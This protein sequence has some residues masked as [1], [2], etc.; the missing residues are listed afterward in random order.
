MLITL[1]TKALR[2]KAIRVQPPV[3]PIFFQL[4]SNHCFIIPGNFTSVNFVQDKY[5]GRNSGPGISLQESAY[6]MDII[7]VVDH[8]RSAMA[9]PWVHY[10]ITV[11]PQRL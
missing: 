3:I 11:D 8:H 7:S 4:F 9:S 6:A 2:C 10:R 5:C 1:A